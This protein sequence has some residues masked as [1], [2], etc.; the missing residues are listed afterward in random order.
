VDQPNILPIPA[1]HV[2]K[3]G[4]ARELSSAQPA[5]TR[6]ARTGAG[7]SGSPGFSE[8]SVAEESPLAGG[9]PLS[10]QQI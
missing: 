1:S 2:Q 3:L 9:D 7:L 4:F 10:W 8:L 6:V 5:K